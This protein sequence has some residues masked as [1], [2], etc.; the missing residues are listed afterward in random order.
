M[1][2]ITA[3]EL[4]QQP[5]DWVDRMRMWHDAKTKAEETRQKEQE[6]KTR[7]R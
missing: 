6:R 2:G 1:L 5:A 4:A 3:T 7:R